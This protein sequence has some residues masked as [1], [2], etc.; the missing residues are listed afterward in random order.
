MLK[1]SRNKVHQTTYQDLSRSLHSQLLSWRN[2]S[3]NAIQIF[4]KGVDMNLIQNQLYFAQTPDS[5]LATP[6]QPGG[7]HFTTSR[8]L[9]TLV[10]SWTSRHIFRE[11]SRLITIKSRRKKCPY[12]SGISSIY[13]Q[14]RPVSVE[15]GSEKLRPSVDSTWCQ[16]NFRDFWPPLC[17]NL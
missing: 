16:P 4:T 8:E 11:S 2:Q 14:F 17:Q 12:I 9:S 7:A 1:S 10:F 15:V 6:Q 3:C 13:T 5:A